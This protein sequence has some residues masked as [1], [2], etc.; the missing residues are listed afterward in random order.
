[1]SKPGQ[2]TVTTSRRQRVLDQLQGGLRT[3]DELRRLAKIPD[4]GLGLTIGDLLDQR[5]IWTAQKNDVRVYG[6]ERRT[7]PVPQFSYPQ[8]RS[9]DRIETAKERR[10]K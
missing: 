4:D 1:M 8:R 9:T 6:L 3:W 7:G 2:A 5:E 10:V